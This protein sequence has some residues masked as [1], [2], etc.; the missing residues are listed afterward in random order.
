MNTTP[1]IGEA[2]IEGALGEY[3][4][5]PTLPP[6]LANGY[7]PHVANHADAER[8]AVA[9]VDRL[10][11]AVSGEGGHDATYRA[12]CECVRF[13]LDEAATYR[14]L[15]RY[16]TRCVPP[17]SESELRHKVESAH[18]HAAHERGARLNQD[19]PGFKRSGRRKVNPTTAAPS[20]HGANLSDLGNA[21]RMVNLH[22]DAMR[23]CAQ[24]GRWYIYDGTRWVEDSTE[25]VVRLAKETIA[26]MY[27]EAVNLPDGD[28]H[29]LLG[30]ALESEKA[31]R[32][33]AMVTL[34][35]SEP[36]IAVGVDAFD[37]DPWLLNCKS[38]TI[39]LRTGECRPHDPADL[40]TKLA[41]VTFDPDAT[42]PTW[43]RFI[44]ETFQGHDDLAWYVQ[45]LL[46]MAMTGDTTEHIMPIF[47]GVG[48]N[49]K[50]VLCEAVMHV[51]GD[52]AGVAAPGLLV[53]RRG[54]DAHPTELA[55]L[56]GKRLVI[57][58]ETESNQHLRIAFVKSATGDATLK[59]RFM[60]QDFFEFRRTHKLILVTNNRPIVDESSNAVWRRLRLIPFSNV[61]PEDRQDKALPRKLQREASGILNTL[62]RGCLDWQAHGL[63]PPPSDVL[64]ATT[65]YRE[66]EDVAGRF[67]ADCITFLP[68]AWVASSR[69]TAAAEAW[70]KENGARLDLRDVHER[71]RAQG[72]TPDRENKRRGWSGVSLPSV[73]TEGVE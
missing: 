45:R 23:F 59:A 47:H 24:T 5:P 35:R 61:V 28:R 14:V 49:G 20:D 60:R 12:A 56:L 57:A 3:F 73:T 72:A 43:E 21:R 37:S 36:G 15:Q 64:L 26:A 2:D 10:P 8:R 22:G 32:I 30:H 13:G 25:A 70:A 46:G 44:A 18:A 55:D 67:V 65:A 52:Y 42:A 50:S 4:T 6:T 53:A 51:L 62:I 29:D 33:A 19:R 71:L 9:Y 1:T 69:I 38:G 58:S 17:W 11:P 27:A 66:A 34:A 54:G 16:N 68:G 31:S 7:A 40:L 41:P 39:D 48:A 63:N